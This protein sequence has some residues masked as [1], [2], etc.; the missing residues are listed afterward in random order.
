MK[1]DTTG[2]MYELDVKEG[3]AAVAVV[4]DLLD[5]MRKSGMGVHFG[6]LHEVEDTNRRI[7]G[8]RVPMEEQVDPD[9]AYFFV[10]E[11]AT[12]A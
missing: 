3:T 2:G 4:S 1:I 9:R 5:K 8:R 7:V 11:Q 10:Q 12:D 6:Y